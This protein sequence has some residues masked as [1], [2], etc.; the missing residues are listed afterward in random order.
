MV[1][2]REPQSYYSQ[3]IYIPSR[4]ARD[5]APLWQKTVYYMLAHNNLIL[6]G[7]SDARAWKNHLSSPCNSTT[8]T[9]SI[10][11]GPVSAVP[12]NTSRSRTFTARAAHQS[13]SSFSLIFTRSCGKYITICGEHQC[14]KNA[15]RDDGGSFVGWTNYMRGKT[16]YTFLPQRLAS[17]CIEIMQMWWRNHAPRGA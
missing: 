10:L 3:R 14:H 16:L 11:E 13:H 1:V 12:I 17:H 15:R 5:I 6:S 8:T 9:E 4:K 2:Y 7:E